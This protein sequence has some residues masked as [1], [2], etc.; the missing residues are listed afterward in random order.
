MS[1]HKNGMT[2]HTP[3]EMGL[4]WGDIGSALKKAGGSAWDVA[5]GQVKTQAQLD[6]LKQQQQQAAIL[7]AQRRLRGGSFMDKYG[8][9][10]VLG[11]VGLAVYFLVIKKK[12]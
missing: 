6:L 11:G 8:L 3:S 12:K 7:E 10:L 1:Y 9:G 2:V 5:S 4:S